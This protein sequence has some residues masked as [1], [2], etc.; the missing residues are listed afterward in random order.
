MKK[1]YPSHIGKALTKSEHS[2]LLESIL[3]EKKPI[4]GGQRTDTRPNALHRHF[5]TADN[6]YG[7]FTSPLTTYENSRSW[8]PAPPTT[9]PSAPTRALSAPV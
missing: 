9:P 2:D 6:R 1:D 8:S 3:F 7:K 4:L 5:D